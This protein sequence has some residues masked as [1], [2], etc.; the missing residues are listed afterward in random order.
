MLC[1]MRFPVLPFPR[2]LD[3]HPFIKQHKQAEKL[4]YWIRDNYAH[5]LQVKD[6]YVG[7]EPWGKYIG[8]LKVL[9]KEA[10]IYKEIYQLAHF[11]ERMLTTQEMIRLLRD[12]HSIYTDLNNQYRSLNKD[13]TRRTMLGEMGLSQKLDQFCNTLEFL[14][15]HL[16]T[17]QAFQTVNHWLSSAKS[18][19]SNEKTLE[20]YQDRS[21]FN[22]VYCK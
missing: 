21:S 17:K 8:F 6:I 13:E 5:C 3:T 19:E 10:F 9:E 12:L 20:G 7:K 16:I 2:E 18:D 22:Y 15:K 14:Q 4:V 11:Q 1:K